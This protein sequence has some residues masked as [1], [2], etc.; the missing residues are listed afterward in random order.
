[1]KYSEL[2]F[3]IRRQLEAVTKAAPRSEV[4]KYL[5]VVGSEIVKAERAL[6]DHTTPPTDSVAVALRAKIVNLGEARNYLLNLSGWV[7]C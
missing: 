4:E 5:E 6:M 2:D 7:C 3:R 1:M